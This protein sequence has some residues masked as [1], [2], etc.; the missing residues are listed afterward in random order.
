[1]TPHRGIREIGAVVQRTFIRK[2]RTRGRYNNVAKY[3]ELQLDGNDRQFVM[4]AADGWDLTSVMINTVLYKP[5]IT[6]VHVHN[7][8]DHQ[9]LTLLAD[10]G[11]RVMEFIATPRDVQVTA[12]QRFGFVL[13]DMG[14][15]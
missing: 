10:N 9:V 6:G 7:T 13:Y 5:L 15:R 14:P 12:P 4:R 1:M 11:Y 2:I 8:A 3:V